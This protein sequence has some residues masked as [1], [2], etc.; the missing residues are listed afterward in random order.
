MQVREAADNA[1]LQPGVV[2]V[3]PPDAHLISSGKTLKLE[4]S[5]AVRFHRP[6]IDSLFE[7]MAR[8]FG[9][10]LIGVILSGS[11]SDGTAGIAA[12]KNAGGT[13]IAQD[14]DE[15]EF[16]AMPKSAIASGCVDKVLRLAEIGPT[17]E[18]LCSR[19]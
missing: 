2:Y 1:P 5:V 11:G 4:H 18:A 16:F 3:A 7:S 8:D 15:A 12:I 13:T 10:R 14:P 6:S 19:Q 9:K 17:I